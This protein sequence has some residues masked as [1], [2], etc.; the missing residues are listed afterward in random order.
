MAEKTS[1]LKQEKERLKST[2]QTVETLLRGVDEREDSQRKDTMDAITNLSYSD[3][4]Q[5]LGFMTAAAQNKVDAGER[6][7]QYLRAARQPYFS[8][9]DFA[10]E[11]AGIPQPFYIGKSG[12]SDR[13][14]RQIVVDWRTPIADIYYANT[15]GK[16]SYMAPK[17]EIKGELSLKR[18]YLIEDGKLE[19]MM[20]VDVSA[21]DDFLQM[22]LGDSKDNRLKDIVSTIQ[23][24]QNEIIRAPLDVPLVVQGVAGSGK[25]TIALHRIAYLI[26][27]YQSEFTAHDFLIIAPNNL[28][29]DYISAVLPELGVEQVRQCT[30]ADLAGKVTG[31]KYKLVDSNARLITLLS[32]D[33]SE[34]EKALIEE[35]SR[36]KGSMAFLKVLEQYVLELT[37][38]I[39]P[40][41]DF[42]LW[43]HV[44]AASSEIRSIIFL[45][46]DAGWEK[47][48]Q[49]L[50]DR[51]N[52]EVRKMRG[53]IEEELQKPFDEEIEHLRYHMAAGE[54]RRLRIVSLINR[55][56]QAETEFRKECKTAVTAYMNGFPK[57]NA[58]KD[59]RRLLSDQEKLC[60]LSH[61]AVTPDAAAYMAR[62]CRLMSK[63]NLV[64]IEDLAP[65]ML[66]HARLKGVDDTIRARFAAIDEA[67]DF[68]ELQFAVLK[69]VL[70]T[71]RFSI[72]G[73][74]SQGI[75]G[76]RGVSSWESLCRNVFHGICQYRVLEQSYRTTIEIMDFANKVLAH[77]HNETLVHAKPL[78][79]HGDLPQCRSLFSG[80]QLLEAIAQRIKEHV[81]SGYSSIAV[82]TKTDAD[83]QKLYRG[84]LSAFPGIQLLKDGDTAYGGG[85]MVLPAHLSKGLEF[86]AVI[87][88]CLND[89]YADSN[90]DIKL[91]YVAITRALHRMDVIRLSGRIQMIPHDSSESDTV[92]SVEKCL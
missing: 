77:I 35:S 39:I 51:L 38:K 5:Q 50:R 86:D 20:D 13:T 56:E 8:R 23:S 69:Q 88:T 70:R 17:G 25:T 11:H 59:Y 42:V 53:K 55:R 28:F 89:D 52:M 67:Q 44:L 87:V 18:H 3:I 68:S 91:L 6:R 58:G 64:E 83:A 27:T 71:D 76:Y 66:L 73:D 31:E 24:E 41:K 14:G 29:L 40:D 46:T 85:I 79:R 21:N 16:V 10:E 54:D 62:Q 60:R 33:V 75:H 32:P 92:I 4:S 36:F 72:F 19:S 26:Y 78:V 22:A 63:K 65:L 2:I 43:G 61:N 81:E 57:I 9:I 90:L 12:L 74:L 1:E 49:D 47:R 84:L 7:R 15:I 30:F 80:K 48:L 45:R 34:E 82:V 37:E